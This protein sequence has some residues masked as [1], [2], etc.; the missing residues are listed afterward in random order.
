MKNVMT[1]GTF[2][3]HLYGYPQAA[4]VRFRMESE[5]ADSVFT[6]NLDRDMPFTAV[7]LEN[8]WLVNLKTTHH[9][10]ITVGKMLDK[11]KDYNPDLPLL[12][13][14]TYVVSD[15]KPVS[16]VNVYHKTEAV[17][18][19]YQHQAD[20]QF[21]IKCQPLYAPKYEDVCTN[22][23]LNELLTEIDNETNRV[24][25]F[26]A[27]HRPRD[28]GHGVEFPAASKL[29]SKDKLS[30]GY[31]SVEMFTDTFDKN[32]KRVVMRGKR[33]GDLNFVWLVSTD[34]YDAITAEAIYLIYVDWIDRFYGKS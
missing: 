32:K 25:N 14:G 31:D 24:E 1:V 19:V 23:L 7:G 5:N 3:D 13:S 21:T 30:V 8:E 18:F 12:M 4:Q 16:V 28:L 6:R 11:L 26:V 9:K 17:V 10:S 20:G 34:Y 2:M 15:A 29:V 22:T 33:D 27:Q